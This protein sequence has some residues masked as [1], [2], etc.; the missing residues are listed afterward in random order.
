MPNTAYVDERPI[1]ERLPWLVNLGFTLAALVIGAFAFATVRSATK[2][3]PGEVAE[4]PP[5]SQP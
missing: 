4:P 5:T 2:P 1:T 3:P